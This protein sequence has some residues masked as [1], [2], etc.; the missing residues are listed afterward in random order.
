MN[1]T[2][3]H[4]IKKQD[5]L[6]VTLPALIRLVINQWEEDGQDTGGSLCCCDYLQLLLPSSKCS[7]L[8]QAYRPT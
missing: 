7:M 5:T 4:L 3:S 2:I 6:P 1:T 8:G